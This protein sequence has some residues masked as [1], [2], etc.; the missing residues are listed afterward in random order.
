MNPTGAGS[1][2]AM[3]SKAWDGNIFHDVL[4]N[5]IAE[6]FLNIFYGDRRE[7]SA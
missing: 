5:S 3:I 6:C 4:L 2:F 7:I 1:M